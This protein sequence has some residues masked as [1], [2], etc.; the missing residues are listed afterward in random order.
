[1]FNYDCDPS[2]YLF[3]FRYIESRSISTLVPTTIDEFGYDLKECERCNS[4]IIVHGIPKSVSTN[5]CN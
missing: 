3:S 2:I 5:M 1:M 4:N